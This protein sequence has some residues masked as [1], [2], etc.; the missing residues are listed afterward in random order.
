MRTCAPSNLYLKVRDW[1]VIKGI[2]GNTSACLYIVVE[3]FRKEFLCSRIE[4]KQS[5]FGRVLLTLSFAQSNKRR[6]GRFLL[7]SVTDKVLGPVLQSLA[8]N[9]PIRSAD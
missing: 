6:E 9:Q 3:N 7:A 4:K 8:P 5:V 2:R 1:P